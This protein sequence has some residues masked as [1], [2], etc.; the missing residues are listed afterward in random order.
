MDWGNITLLAGAIIGS[1]AFGSLATWF[2]SKNKVDTELKKL[3]FETSELI[4]GE[5]QKTV[6]ELRAAVLSLESK[7]FENERLI[8]QYEQENVQLAEKYDRATRLIKN[9]EKNTPLNL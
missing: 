3:N 1:G 6:N 9:I 4:T 8:M 2:L 7:Q 5:L